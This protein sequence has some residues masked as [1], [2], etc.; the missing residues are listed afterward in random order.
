MKRSLS[1]L[2]NKLELRKKFRTI[3]SEIPL[4]LRQQ[5]ADDAA[6]HL[7]AHPL[8]AA[9]RHIACYQSFGDEM[10]TEPF[11]KAIW[12][13]NKICYLPTL[14]ETKSLHFAQYD[15]GDELQ[16]NQYGIPE[17]VNAK[18]FIQP[19]KLDLVLLP[20]IAFDD[21]GNRLGTGGG[22]YDRTFAFM[23]THTAKH[24][25]LLGVGYAAQYC[26]SLMP[27]AWDIALHGVL[28]EKQ[29]REF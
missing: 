28:T 5:Y 14:T 9:A 3:R 18:H 11:I 10:P 23:L 29:L 25:I 13:A 6:K 19:E 7:V 16:L 22:Y 2:Q 21:Q 12:Q 8:F 1:I 17:P 4:E 24:P 20:L 26:A 15:Q 27:E